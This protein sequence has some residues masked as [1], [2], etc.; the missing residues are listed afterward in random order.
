MA[1]VDDSNALS[2]PEGVDTFDEKPADAVEAEPAAVEEEP[3]AE[4]PAVE[5]EPAAEEPAAE[6]PAAE[7]AVAEEEPAAEEP[8][9][10]EELAA[11]EPAAE[12]AVAEEEPAAEEEPVAE[13]E[14]AAEEEPVAEEEA[15]AEEEPVAEEEAAAEEGAE[16]P[17]AEEESPAEGEPEDPPA[18]SEEAE[19][20]EDGEETD[21]VTPL[22]TAVPVL[23]T[24]EEVEGGEEVAEKKAPA[25]PLSAL[26]Y[27]LGSNDHVVVLEAMTIMGSMDLNE[28][29]K[30]GKVVAK[31]TAPMSVLQALKNH[32]KDHE[33]ISSKGLGLLLSL[34]A[35]NEK[36]CKSA[37][38]ELDG[39]KIIIQNMKYHKESMNLQVH[40][41]G[42]LCNLST[43][44]KKEV[45]KMLDSGAV[46]IIV[47]DMVRWPKLAYVQRRGCKTF[48]NMMA[49]KK[50]IITVKTTIRNKKGLSTMGRCLDSFPADSS[51]FAEARRAMECF[52]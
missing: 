38:K 36:G 7:E 33:E 6:E 42:L 44:G 23:E 45:T 12:E 52:I 8:A 47:A 10:E 24:S 13:E 17:P 32:G 5:E 41:L 2:V 31:G 11:E 22:A 34:T 4:E 49:E 19:V 15:A 1:E 29:N 26:L 3:A 37:I 28:S 35:S 48:G 9:A 25:K 16:D 50:K 51:T 27:D 30:K 43:W 20:E 21:V 39:T 14:A 18:E 46:D 40:G